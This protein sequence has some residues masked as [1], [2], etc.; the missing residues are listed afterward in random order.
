MDAHERAV[1][2]WDAAADMHGFARNHLFPR[3]RA[4]GKCGG[5]GNRGKLCFAQCRLG[6]IVGTNRNA[7]L[8]VKGQNKSV[9][10]QQRHGLA[11]KIKANRLHRHPPHL[12]LHQNL[13]KIFSP[14]NFE[15]IQ[16][17]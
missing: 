12:A 11:R 7:A 13:H 3:G 15:F 6:G 10:G 1:R 17:V 8:G 2:L 5:K 14:N 9:I 16:M 4:I